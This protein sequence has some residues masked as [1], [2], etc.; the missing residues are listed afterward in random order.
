ME[1][2][3][4]AARLIGESTSEPIWLCLSGGIDSEAMA[5]AFLL[6]R[7]PFQ[8]AI[9]RFKDNLNAHDICSAVGFCEEL[10][11]P[12]KY[13]DF[14]I[15]EFY[16]SGR[17]LEAA[18]NYRCYSPQFAV[19]IELMKRIQGF[20]VMAWN[21]TAATVLPN[22]KVVLKFPSDL[23][24][25]YHRYFER[26]QRPGVGLFFFYTPELAYS[27]LRLPL[28]QDYVFQRGDKKG[29][30]TDYAVKCQLFRDGGFDVQDRVQKYSG[31][32]KLNAYYRERF[33]GTG[34]VFDKYFRW[35]LHEICPPPREELFQ[36]PTRYLKV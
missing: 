6:A 31:F 33:G 9:M 8:A 17:H 28:M 29:K 30:S 26:E 13:F 22:G 7:V 10:G 21:P 25:C 23:F 12:F 18:R 34:Q 16:D 1:E 32:E 27:F 35:P 4:H 20:P 3:I 15:I 19:H 2:A 14:D 36:V 11:I 24:L 5:R